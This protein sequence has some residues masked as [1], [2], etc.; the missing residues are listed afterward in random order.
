M[1]GSTSKLSDESLKPYIERITQEHESVDDKSTPRLLTKKQLKVSKQP[2]EPNNVHCSFLKATLKT[3]SEVPA[4]AAAIPM[5]ANAEDQDELFLNL[6]RMANVQDS[7]LVSFLGCQLVG[8]T[9]NIGFGD[10]DSGT[11]R[12]Y[13]PTKGKNI[14]LKDRLRLCSNIADGL[15]AVDEAG[16]VHGEINADNCF[17][18]EGGYVFKLG[19]FLH[20]KNQAAY[21]SPEAKA[22]AEPNAQDD[23][24]AFGVLLWTIFNGGIPPYA[25]K[26]EQEIMHIQKVDLPPI[27]AMPA[28]I[29]DVIDKCMDLNPSARPDI[30]WLRAELADQVDQAED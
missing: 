29:R 4:M 1:G 11:L 3:T 10:C 12:S 5:S 21:L 13:L 14:S 20:G 8:K 26:S 30:F 18:S 17:A 24:W 16:F 2:Y 28:A 25:D 9:L 7:N 27:D 15:A 19:P 23:I 22:G 6:A